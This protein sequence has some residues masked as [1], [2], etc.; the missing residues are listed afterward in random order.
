MS[1]VSLQ[2][3]INVFTTRGHELYDAE[4]VSQLDHALQ[5][6]TFAEVSCSRASLI[7]ACLLHDVGHLIHALGNDAAERGIDDRHEYRA[8]PF[9]TSLF[10]PEVT[11]PIRLH[12][13]AKRYLCATDSTYWE[14]LSA[15]SR[16]SLILQGGMFSLEEACAFIQQPYAQD[17]VKL[18]RWDEQG[19][20][21]GQKTPGIEHFIPFLETC[22]GLAR[23]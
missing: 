21:P 10:G 7:S 11:E 5:C 9:L 6:A 1:P 2:T 13:N 12:V 20:V 19:K 8:I 18:R 4:A 17:A 15:P 22:K 14:A 16:R 3:L 23:K